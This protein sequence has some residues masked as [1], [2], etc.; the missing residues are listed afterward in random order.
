MDDLVQR[1]KQAID[2]GKLVFVQLYPGD[3]T[4][5]QTLEAR[6]VAANDGIVQV[7]LVGGTA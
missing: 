1:I 3:E 5:M 2:D 6:A 4:E 7:S